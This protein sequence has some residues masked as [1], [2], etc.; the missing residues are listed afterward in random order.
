MAAAGASGANIPVSIANSTP[1]A[2]SRWTIF[3]PGSTPQMKPPA[4]GYIIE[5]FS[6]ICRTTRAGLVFQLLARVRMRTGV[7]AKPKERRI[8]FSRNR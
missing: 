2:I 1:C 4:I 8:W 5:A 6:R 7:P 3:S